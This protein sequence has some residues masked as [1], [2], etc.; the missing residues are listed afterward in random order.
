MEK[1]DAEEKNAEPKPAP[2]PAVVSVK[3]KPVQAQVKNDVKP[4]PK[5]EADK[6]WHEIKEKPIEMFAL[7]NQTVAHYCRPLTI[8]PTRL[9][10]IPTAASVLPALELALGN[11]YT[12]ELADKYLIVGR[13]KK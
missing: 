7:P 1:L 4:E 9:Y 3:N 12:V 11:K 13:S 10:V 8:E 6:I 5:T 2:K